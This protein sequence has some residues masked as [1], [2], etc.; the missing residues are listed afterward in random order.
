[1]PFPAEY[2]DLLGDDSKALLYLATLME[3]GSPQ[4][5]PVWF[6]IDGEYVLINTNQGRVKDINM[7]QRPRLAMVIQDPSDGYRYLG[8]RGEVVSYTTEGADE[9]ISM[10]SLRYDGQAWKYRPEQR[11]IIFKIR[12]ISFDKH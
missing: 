3:D 5:T 1:M 4:L 8:M 9:H 2:R 11:R 10:L 12:P 6:S 7:K